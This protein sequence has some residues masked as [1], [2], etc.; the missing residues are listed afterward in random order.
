MFTVTISSSI[1]LYL[2]FKKE[3]KSIPHLKKLDKINPSDYIENK[4]EA[5]LSITI[6]AVVILL[7]LFKDLIFDYT[8]IKLEN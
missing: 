8:Q 1:Y 6:L 7:V 3:F 5:K 2:I 4:N